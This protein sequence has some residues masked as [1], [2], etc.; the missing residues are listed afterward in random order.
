M[1]DQ[2]GRL[3]NWV[4]DH[5]IPDGSLRLRIPTAGESTTLIAVPFWP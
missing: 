2:M 3:E 5:E 4:K 1:T